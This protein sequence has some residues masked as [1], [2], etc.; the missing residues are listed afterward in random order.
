MNEDMSKQLKTVENTIM[1]TVKT[2]RQK[3]MYR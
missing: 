3:Q 2:G 1:K